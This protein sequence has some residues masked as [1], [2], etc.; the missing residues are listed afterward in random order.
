MLAPLIRTA[1]AT[2]TIG[3]LA[4]TIAG[5][6]SANGLI[7]A[8]KMTRLHLHL[9]SLNPQPLPPRWSQGGQKA[10]NPQPLPPRWSQGGQKALN[11]QPLPP[12]WSQGG[13]KALNPQPLPPLHRPGMMVR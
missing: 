8:K 2:L 4:L 3:V 5:P 11:P 13:L 1:A 7:S 6:A 9:K 10:L 12:R